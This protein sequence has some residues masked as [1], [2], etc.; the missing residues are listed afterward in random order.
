MA[1]VCNFARFPN[2][3][4]AHWFQHHDEPSGGR[5]DGEDYNMGLIDIAGR[6]YEELTEAFAGVNPQLPALHRL[7]MPRPG[8]LPD[9]TVVPIAGAAAPIA[10]DD[11]GLG[12]WDKPRTLLPGFHAPAPDVPFADV[13][14][15]WRPDGL[16]LALLGS[17]YLDFDLLDD[18]AHFPLGETFQVHLMVDAGHGVRHLAIHLTPRRSVKYP[19]R[20]EIAPELHRYELGRPA[21]AVALDGRVQQLE[22]PLPHIGLEAFVPAADL[23]RD[24]LAA[25]TRLRVNVAVV[26]YYRERTMAWAGTPTADPRGMDRTLRPVVLAAPE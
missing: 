21:A 15:A 1:A 8:P 13:H 23:G 18:A 11:H 10:L 16:Y 5:G 4:G 22:K 19:D 7:A 12:D 14:L 25:G 17:N 2:V 3:V 20:L 9:T 24:Q 26:G 6:P